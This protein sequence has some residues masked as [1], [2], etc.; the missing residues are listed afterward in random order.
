MQLQIQLV[1]LEQRTIYPARVRVEGDRISS[2]E[3]LER[4]V[5]GAGYLLPGFVDAHVHIESSMLPPAEFARLAVVHGTVATV[6]DPHEIANVLGVEGVHYMLEEA[7]KVPF[8]FCIGAPSCVPA[9]GF[10]TAGA[11]IDARAVAELLQHPEI[12]YLSEMMNFPGVLQQDPEVMA[13]IATAKR[14]HKP[15]DG[16]AP[17]LR[18]EGAVQYFGAGITTDHEC[19]TYEE[20]LEKAR[21]GVK[22]LIR[23][24]SAARN[25]A[26]LWPLINEFPEQI[27]FCS[28]DKHP[29]DLI[30]GHINQLVARA[31]GRG[32]DLFDVLR[33][34]CVHP[35]AHYSLPVGQ[36]KVGDPADFI[37]VQDLQ[38]FHVRE[39]W[40]DGQCVAKDGKTLIP[41]KTGKVLNHFK[42]RV[43]RPEDFALPCDQPTARCR[44]IGA[45][46]GQIVT[47]SR[48]E[49]LQTINGRLEP[50]T[51]RDILKIAVVN[52]YTE[53]APVALGLVHGFGL[54]TGA[55]ASSVAHD[56]HNIVA[57]GTNDIALC[58]AVNAVIE[59]QGGV[60]AVD[61]ESEVRVLPLPIAGLMSPEDGY[62]LARQYSAIDEWVKSELSGGL[63]APFMVLSFL[64][65]PVIPDLK[66]TDLGLFDVSK[67]DFTTVAVEA[68]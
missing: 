10:E 34:A 59:A 12:A 64:A 22:I 41:R 31:V 1:D 6:S 38:D 26:A 5:E 23:E 13:K 50:D 46:D 60:S 54:Q 19:F 44:I 56:S 39:T 21:L 45:L 7:R 17:G 52:R 28:D 32:C 27:M 15:I 4:P 24:G 35:V 9:T 33:A 42:A 43:R 20:G 11:T 37:I 25:F 40:L 53:R 47:E 65:L 48:E 16:H 14:L 66:I 63:Q 55:I 29:D 49:T 8:K 57:V 68:D 2:I 18:G 58:R 67:F 62:T 30:R 51:S 61:D 3:R 36:L